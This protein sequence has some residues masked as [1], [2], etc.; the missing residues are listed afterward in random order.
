MTHGL[1][2]ETADLDQVCLGIILC[3]LFSRDGRE[4]VAGRWPL[5]TVLRNR[6]AWRM[7][8]SE[9]GV[10]SLQWMELLTDLE[11]VLKIEIRDD[12]LAD[13]QVSA[14][15]I[16]NAVLHALASEGSAGKLELT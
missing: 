13:S 8:L 12:A 16:A 9:L 15:S 3:R 14:V 6:D 1:A 4:V 10:D 2:S 11:A 5:A 7:S